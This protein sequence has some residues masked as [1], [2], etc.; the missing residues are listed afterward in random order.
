MRK[1]ESRD[2]SFNKDPLSMAMMRT[3]GSRPL[4]YARNGILMAFVVL[5]LLALV[6]AATPTITLNKPLNNTYISGYNSQSTTFEVQETSGANLINYP[7]VLTLNTTYLVANG[8]LRYDCSNIRF[9]I[10]GGSNLSYWKESDCNT[11]QTRFWVKLPLLNASSRLFVEAYFLDFSVASQSDGTSVFD[12]FDDFDGTNLNTTKWT[13]QVAPIPAVNNSQVTVTD[14]G[15]WA[16]SYNLPTRAIIEAKIAVRG[17]APLMR[18][19]A[20]DSFSKWYYYLYNANN[21]GFGWM[22]WNQPGIYANSRSS[23][24]YLEYYQGALGA[25]SYYTKFSY[26]TTNPVGFAI[27]DQY[28][29]IVYSYSN[30]SYNPPTPNTDLHPNVYSENPSGVIEMDYIF[31]RNVSTSEP[32]VTPIQ[33]NNTITLNVSSTETGAMSYYLDNDAQV[34]AC[35]NCNAF[36]KTIAPGGS[37]EPWWNV[38]WHYRINLTVN[39]GYA[40]RAKNSVTQTIVDFGQALSNLSEPGTIDTNSIRVV[41]KL[42]G[43]EM[44]SEVLKWVSPSKAMVRFKLTKNQTLSR[45]SNYAYHVYFDTLENGNKTARP[46]GGLP[47]IYALASHGR[48]SYYRTATNDWGTWTPSG[49]SFRKLAIADFDNDGDYDFVTNEGGTEYIYL[50]NGDDFWSFTRRNISTHSDFW[51]SDLV[52]ADFNEDGNLD[53]ATMYTQ[54]SASHLIVLFG[55]GNGTFNET[56]IENFYAGNDPSGIMAGDFDGDK[57]M[58]IMVIP[59]PLGGGPTGASAYPI[60]YWGIGNGGFTKGSTGFG[61]YSY[62]YQG[63]WSIDDNFDGYDDIYYGYHSWENRVAGPGPSR[64]WG[65][66]TSATAY[67]YSGDWTVQNHLIATT[68]FDY[69]ND[70]IEDLLMGGAWE[71]IG[72]GLYAEYGQVGGS[73]PFSGAKMISSTGGEMTDIGVPEGLQGRRSHCRRGGASRDVHR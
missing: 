9:R 10:I 11:D 50:N 2:Y 54:S 52:V 38:N 42:T 30:P 34:I 12:F 58:D 20:V 67:I 24:D 19:G 40:P 15:L 21:R 69:N 3:C 66:P 41:S 36:Q 28:R 53:V 17:S 23:S 43:E 8:M 65:S 57:H 49:Y 59:N 13:Y 31:V 18:V 29:N 33:L 60:P 56:Y 4:S 35:S 72:G 68:I 71:G 37:N 63:Y 7:V 73:Q 26:D 14:N 6:Y 25:G 70:G 5:G 32:T 51:Y 55:N 16:T 22:L 39:T 48:F 46:V 61:S 1:Q 64:V 27:L 47:K 45:N 62:Y 44:P